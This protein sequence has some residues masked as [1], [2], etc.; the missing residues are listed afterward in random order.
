MGRHSRR[1]PAPKGDPADATAARE[2][3]SARPEER[4]GPSTPPGERTGPPYG[5]GSPAGRVGARPPR[6]TRAYDTP[7]FGTGRVGP[8]GQV[9]G[10]H[11]EQREPGGGWGE[12]G[13]AG[14]APG[15]PRGPGLS[16]PR[17]RQAPQG[18]RTP[19]ARGGGGPRQ[20]YLDAFERGS[21]DPSASAAS[22]ASPSASGSA[23]ATGSVFTPA[24]GTARVRADAPPPGSR[25]TAG[26]RSD[27]GG[28]VRGGGKGRAFTGV[29]AAAVTIVLAVVVAGQV[30]DGRAGEAA[31]SRSA[32]DRAG[33]EQG[34]VPGAAEEM[35]T[36]DAGAGSG[37]GPSAAAPLTYAQKMGTVYPLS[38]TLKG[39]G[40]FDAIEGVDKA[41]GRGQKYTYR[42]DVE[43][44]LGLDGELF[45]QAVQKTLND[46]RSWAHNGART[47][48]RVHSGHPDFVITLASPGT[49]ADWCAKS[50]L[51]TTID[52][53]SC[54]S[55]ATERV[56]INAYRWAKGAKTY[57]D[58]KIY[59]Y[60][61]MLINHE[62]GHR[63]GHNHVTCD[64]DGDL[65]PVMQQQTKFLEYDGI[66]C[67]P[68]AWPYPSA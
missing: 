22:A 47:F 51:D 2:R 8:A 20:E 56:M 17:Q 29:A 49:T 28:P 37:S 63:L 42:V 26:G 44:G 18:A 15:A 33:A 46:D 34:S 30:A 41:P 7:A 61:Q 59:P 25:A 60:R 40:E 14:A 66:R 53:V 4:G 36:S 45:A 54:D 3:Q 64:K 55:A 57:G 67:R 19:G 48:E 24:S 35:G 32:A 12:F 9:R 23:P 27:G 43:K 6:G 5:D 11:P 16:L 38:A 65:A 62:V 31:A 39:S 21:D 50:G 52:N 1:G 13:A 10:G 58:D 68:N